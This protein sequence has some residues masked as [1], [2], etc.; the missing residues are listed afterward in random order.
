MGYL[1]QQ[2]V[3]FPELS[4]TENVNFMASVYGVPY[5]KRS[6][7]VQ[8]VLEL[9]E[10]WDSRHKLAD[11]LSG[12]MR[13][14]LELATTLLHQPQLIMMDEPT[15]GID[16]VLRAKFWEQFKA[17]SN[18]GRTIFVTTQYVT[19]ADYCDVVAILHRGRLLVWGT[20]EEI[21]QHVMG[22]EAIDVTLPEINSTTLQ[23]LRRL[24]NLKKTQVLGSDKVRLIFDNAGQ[25][26][27]ET[28]A[29][30]QQN[31]LTATS[32]EPYRP[33]FDEI[34]IE[35]LGREKDTDQDD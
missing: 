15:A 12:G 9:V 34:F 30:L 31:D 13:R 20:P 16:P 26:L 11:K 10:L 25:A 22:G 21:R 17:L 8:A 14:R 33:S 7:K 5:A 27:Q 1:P 29:F 23:L 4:V 28:V 3:L 6:E 35:L 24:P 32:I 19:E 18:E 2:F